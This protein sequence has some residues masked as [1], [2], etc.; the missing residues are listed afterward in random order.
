MRLLG[1]EITSGGSA[2]HHLALFSVE[3]GSE[4]S[5]IEFGEEGTL[6]DGVDTMDG[7]ELGLLNLMVQHASI[8]GPLHK[9]PIVTW[10]TKWK[11]RNKTLESASNF[12]WYALSNKM[13]QVERAN[14]NE[15][16]ALS[17]SFYNL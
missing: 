5:Q 8:A 15:S 1:E 10:K 7:A 11:E 13:P 4:S 2:E 17:L 9:V 12:W 16:F 6:Q 3:I 14:G